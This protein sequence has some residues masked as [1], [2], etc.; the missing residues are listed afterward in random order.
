[1]KICLLLLAVTLPAAAQQD[2]YAPLRLYDGSWTVA[3]HDAASGNSHTDTLVNA[4]SLVGQYFACQQTVN[5]K[6]AALVV[7]VPASAPGHYSVQNVLPDGSA[8][9]RNDL[10]ILGSHWIYSSRDDENGKTT[11]YRTTNDFTGNDRIH[12]ESAKSTD[13]KT[14]T[15]TIS[16][17]EV[18]GTTAK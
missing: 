6:V 4:C 7:F 2:V 3:M 15:V 10:A 8:T 18:R 17:D 5:G 16:G 12:F 9:G 11:W 13:G 1:M 14:W